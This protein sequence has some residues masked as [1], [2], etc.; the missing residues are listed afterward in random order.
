LNKVITSTPI[1]TKL[2]I[3]NLSYSQLKTFTICPRQYM[4]HHVWH[5]ATIRT[6]GIQFGSNVHRI[7][8][9]VNKQIRDGAIES[10][11]VQATI[12][13]KWQDNWFQDQA[14]NKSFRDSAERQISAWI[15]F[16]KDS[17]KEFSI[18][19]IEEPFLV[20]TTGALISGRFD[21]ILRNGDKK[22]LLDFKTGDAANY[23]AQLSFYGMCFN[24]K[25]GFEPNDLFVFYLNKSTLDRIV[26]LK[27]D[28]FM[29]DVDNSITN[30]KER[31]F[32]AT[33]G[34]HCKDCAYNQICSFSKKRYAT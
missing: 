8:Q 21:L 24:L 5:L 22:V 1:R 30:I 12:R 23:D 29:Q 18:D 15:Q 13:A 7:L 32:G 33:P 6:G 25:Y 31:N 17:L 16:V 11:D 34:D 4:Y 20:P 9:N 10:I 3:L 26:P 28:I 27:K 14:T 19:S 2:D